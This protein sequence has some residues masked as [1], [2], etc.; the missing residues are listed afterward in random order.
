MKEEKNGCGCTKC[1]KFRKMMGVSECFGNKTDSIGLFEA[2]NF[3]K[4]KPF[5]VTF[6][7]GI[8]VEW[9]K[10]NEAEQMTSGEKSE[11]E[12]IVKS[13]KKDNGEDFEKRYPGRGKQVMYATA[14]KRAM[15]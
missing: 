9:K 2:I 10:L 12:K 15:D 4:N 8:N 7:E 14:T 11:R 5:K 1:K 6:N 3:Q 13:M